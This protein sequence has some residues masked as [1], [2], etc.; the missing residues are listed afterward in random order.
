MTPADPST[1]GDHDE[2]TGVP[3]SAWSDDS[4]AGPLPKFEENARAGYGDSLALLALVVPL[5]AQGLLLAYHF[6][7][8]AVVWVVRL[9]AVAV[10]ALLLVADANRLGSIDQDGFPRGGAGLLFAGLILLWVVVYPV[11]YFRRRHFGR[12]NFGPLALLVALFFTAAPYVQH[13]M[14]FGVFGSAPPTCISREVVAAVDELVRQ[15]PGCPPV[16]AVSRHREI[17]YDKAKKRRKGQCLVATST[18]TITVT[19]FVTVDPVNGGF[20]VEVEPFF[21]T[22]PPGCT[23]PA[24]IDQLNHLFRTEAKEH[25]VKSVTGHAEVRYDRDSKVRYGRCRV[26]AADWN[27]DVAY[28]VYWVDRKTGSFQVEIEDTPDR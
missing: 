15:S 20:S 4:L 17:L 25:L 2:R 13:F 24:V 28:K 23:D 5:V 11:A 21:A 14:A 26:T 9:G 3:G 19:Y 7:S 18:E 27:G 10:T 16:E 22:D 12:P 8:D 1:P 6:D